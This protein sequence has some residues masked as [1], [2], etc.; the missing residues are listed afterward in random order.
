MRAYKF[1]DEKFGIKSLQEKRLK[2]SVLDD[3]NDPFELLP[4]EMSDRNKRSALNA[5]RKQMASNRGLLCFSATWKEPVL[6]AHYADKHKGLCLAFDVPQEACKAV[7]Y[8]K[9]RLKLPARPSLPD[10]EALIF[11]KYV[12]WQYEQ[13]LRIW[14]SL[15]TRDNGLYFADFG[16]TLKLKKV[17]A[18]ARCSLS[19]RQIAAAIGPLSDEVTVMKSRAGFKEFEIVKDQ[20]G[21]RS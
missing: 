14:A 19:E 13:E 11:T 20:L 16:P 6:W 18:G 17:I 8:E 1:L 3:L 2:I 12:N 15:N 5:T 7:N 10:A 9:R 21:F 4:Y